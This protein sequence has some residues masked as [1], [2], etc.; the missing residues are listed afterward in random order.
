MIISMVAAADENDAIGFRNELLVKLPADFARM[1]ELTNG[2][3]LIMGSKTHKSIGRPLP[4]RLNIVLTRD[5]SRTYPG[6]TVVHSLEEGLEAAR[7]SGA[8]EAVIFGGETLYREALPIADVIHLTRI[9]AGLGEADA[10][11]PMIPV[12]QWHLEAAEHHEKDAE[13]PHSMTFQTWRRKGSG[14][15]R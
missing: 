9:H 7:A 4:G 8:E 15:H 2:K 1:K 12:E 5:A 6:C 10:F 3:P 13:N 11:F 14:G